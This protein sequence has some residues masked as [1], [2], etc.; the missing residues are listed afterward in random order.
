MLL[1]KQIAQMII[2]KLEKEVQACKQAALV[3]L[4]R[5]FFQNNNQLQVKVVV[6]SLL[7]CL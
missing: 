4:S 1:M 5:Y 6:E 2:R 7:E 3:P